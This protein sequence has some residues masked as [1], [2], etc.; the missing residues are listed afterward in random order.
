MG[1]AHRGEKSHFWRGGTTD[2]KLK[3]RGHVRYSLWRSSIFERDNYTCV[4]CGV[5]GAKLNADHYPQSFSSLIKKY[6][7]KSLDDGLVCQ[8]LWD[9]K[10]GRTHCV[11]IRH[12]KKTPIIIYFI[13]NMI[14]NLALLSFSGE[15]M[16]ISQS[17][18][19]GVRSATK[20]K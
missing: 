4:L 16:S 19:K 14:K 8:E 2:L 9:I 20:A 12:P 18:F 11:L 7:I 13:K 6:S 10:N 17:G 5:K 3:I 1:A 15:G